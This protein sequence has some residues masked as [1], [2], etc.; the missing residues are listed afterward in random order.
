[1]EK[2][3]KTKAKN[4]KEKCEACEAERKYG[5]RSYLHTCGKSNKK[6]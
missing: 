6:T 5:G 4:R 2:E 1:M 3:V